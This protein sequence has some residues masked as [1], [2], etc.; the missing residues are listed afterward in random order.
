MGGPAIGTGDVVGMGAGD[1]LGIG[2]GDVFGIGSGDGIE[3]GTRAAVVEIGTIS[4]GWNL[5]PVRSKSSNPTDRVLKF[6]G[7]RTATVSGVTNGGSTLHKGCSAI[8]GSTV[9]TPVVIT[10]DVVSDG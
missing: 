7:V 4:V 9:I 1:E 6:T 5:I 10:I 8:T 3:L 2:T